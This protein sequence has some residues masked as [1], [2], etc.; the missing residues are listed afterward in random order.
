MSGFN[1]ERNLPHQQ[2]AVDT[3]L[4]LFDGVYA[5]ASADRVSN[6]AIEHDSGFVD[7]LMAMQLR[8][9]IDTADK[10]Y[11]KSNSNVLDVSME[12]GTGKTYTY[13][14]TMF[15]LNRQLGIRKFI[16]V[17]PTL[18]IKAGTVNFLRSDSAKEHFRQDYKRELKVHVVESAKGSK[19]NKKSYMP[20]AVREFVEANNQ[21][22]HVLVINAGMINSKTM[23]DV[24]DVNLF[25]RYNTPFSAIASVRPLTIVGIPMMPATHST[26]SRPPCRGS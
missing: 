9:G 19:K 3:I 13:T 22:I 10:K 16:V 8:N 5:P 25:D 24:F 1:F 17:V 11:R 26:R 2:V 12:T 15:E 7:D 4:G 21:Q 23:S 6:P 18:P 20:Q 14:K